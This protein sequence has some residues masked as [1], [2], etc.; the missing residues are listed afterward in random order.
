V[1]EPIINAMRRLYRDRELELMVTYGPKIDVS[2]DEVD[3]AEILSNLIDN[4]C[5]WAATRVEVS[6]HLD[7]GAVILLIDDDGPGITETRSV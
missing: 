4:A 7:K 1:L 6:W 2:M 5:K 3:L